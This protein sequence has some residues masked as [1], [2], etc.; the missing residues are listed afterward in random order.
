MRNYFESLCSE[1]N[2]FLKGQ[3]IWLAQ[4]EAEQSS[5]CRFNHGRM[6]QQGT[7]NQS[8]LTLTLADGQKHSSHQLMLS[9]NLEDDTALLKSAITALRDRLKH[10][11][12]DPLFLI[13][14]HPENSEQLAHQEIPDAKAICQHVTENCAQ[15]D[16][17]GIVMAG[18]QYSAF[19][20][21]LGQR[22]WFEAKDFNLDYSLY[23]HT[24]KAVKDRLAGPQW[25]QD[26]FIE[27]L[28]QSRNKLSLLKQ[29]PVEL[30]PGK[31]RVYLTPDALNEIV[32][33]MSFSCRA[34]QDKSSPLRRLH[35]H[36]V[37]LN[38]MVNIS[39]DLT[40]GIVPC[41][42]GE[43]FVMPPQLQLLE[44][45]ISKNL[46]TSPRTELE[47]GIKHNGAG[48]G[49]QAGSLILNTGQLLQDQALSQL[50]NGLYISN[51]WYLNYSDPNSA[52]ITGMTRFAC[53]LVKDGKLTTPINALRFD[54][55]LYH[56]LGNNLEALTQEQELLMDTG[57]Y[58]RRS[59]G[60]K[61]LP[62]A[63][64]KD[65]CFTL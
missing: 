50:G 51:L 62:G 31:Y 18:S 26:N 36:E 32:N 13:N 42:Q 49:E 8:Q 55:S 37:Q 33:L 12:D 14:K 11:P 58:F 64:V 24:D 52:R 54:D 6:R 59:R 16:F 30:K 35:N 2:S 7:I 28:E 53:F 21:S 27:R 29:Q 43:G 40:S 63:L 46:L 38:P 41:F 9:N 47:Y 44:N 3:E 39:M 5:Y 60:A 45:G 61:A 4:L 17:V 56:M 48:T 57:S 1:L 10:L 19:A 34:V 20:N 15:D 23:L 25:Q 65:M 22:N